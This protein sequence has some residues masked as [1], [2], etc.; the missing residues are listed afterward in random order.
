[1]K[2]VTLLHEDICKI[3]TWFENNYIF[4]NKEKTQL[5]CFH[6]PYKKV[7]LTEHLY[8]HSEHCNRCSCQSM[9]YATKI[10][11]LGIIFDESFSFVNHI[12]YVAKRLRTVCAVIYKIRS[13]CDLRLRKLT[14]KA[15]GETV[16]RYGITIYGLASP[17][18][19]SVL[20]RIIQ[21]IT[22][23]ITYGTNSRAVGHSE[24][25]AEHGI[26]DIKQLFL[27][28][29]LTKHY[30][31]ETFKTKNV[32]TR[33]LRKIETFVRAKAFTNYGKRTRAFYVSSYFNEIPEVTNLSSLRKI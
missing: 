2:S 21:K 24:L 11:Y 5:I 14:Y 16:L 19:L 17:Y 27:S 3:M 7:E 10:K 32:K 26:F 29:V 13:V 33:D 15:L 6:S 20:N 31:D 22:H 18:R 12:Q 30:F 4:V 25:M 9:P 23:N 1:M 28:V 8:L